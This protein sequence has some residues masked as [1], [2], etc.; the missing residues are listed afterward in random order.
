[1]RSVF[2]LN[3]LLCMTMLTTVLLFTARVTLAQAPAIQPCQASPTP[4]PDVV[5]SIPSKVGEKAS[6]TV[7]DSNIPDDPGLV[8]LLAP[9]SEK[10]R[11]LST[12][13]GTLDGSLTKTPIGAGTVG[14]FVTDA[15]LSE[16]RRATTKKVAV[17]ISNAGG[18]R[19]NEIAEGQ[20]RVSDVFE[21]MPFENELITLDLTGVQLKKLLQIGTRDPQAG[22]QIEYRWNEQNRTEVLNAKLLDEQGKAY[23]IDPNA[24]YTVV[25]IDYLYKLNS[26]A[27]ALLQEGKNFNQLKVTIRDAVI[28]YVKA[29][30]AAGRHIKSHM[31]NRYVQIG[32]GPVKKETPSQ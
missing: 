29:E 27:Y 14:H 4:K 9:Y 25:T 30:T 3:R 1:M 26:G 2:A 8:K 15:L 23:E 24:T 22:A 19:K 13:I 18:L 32:P 16:A 28:D 10:V 7:V 20:L 21:L 6:Q 12:I 11:A 17:A 5:A 31:D